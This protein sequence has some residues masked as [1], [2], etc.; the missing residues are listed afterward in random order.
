MVRLFGLG[1]QYPDSS[2][3]FAICKIPNFGPGFSTV[4]I[5]PD[6]ARTFRPD[7]VARGRSRSHLNARARLQRELSRERSFVDR[8]S[9]Y[10]GIL[11]VIGLA[12]RRA[13]VR[14]LPVPT[15][16]RSFECRQIAPS[17]RSVFVS[18]FFQDCRLRPRSIAAAHSPAFKGLDVAAGASDS[19]GA[20]ARV[21]FRCR[22]GEVCRA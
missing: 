20:K 5:R 19:S 3:N 12:S 8:T 16:A 10:L 15:Q 17:N 2:T 21:V 4:A 18:P 6:L 1:G 7:H 14:Q 9:N 13:S 11:G 22:A